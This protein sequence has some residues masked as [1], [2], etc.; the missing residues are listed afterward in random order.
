MWQQTVKQLVEV[1]R[2]WADQL[3]F[4]SSVHD[5][6]PGE[7]VLDLD[8]GTDRFHLEPA[9]FSGENLP[10]IVWLY[11]FPTMKRVRL[12]SAEQNAWEIQS[13]DGVPFHKSLDKNA[14][15]QI[16]ADL[17]ASVA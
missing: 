4:V 14:F 15:Q 6:I 7:P 11:A 8:R 12:V 10:A 17:S 13:S 2:A 5:P 16:L 9:E 3:G 1:V